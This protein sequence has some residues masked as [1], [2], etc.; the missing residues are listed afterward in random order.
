MPLDVLCRSCGGVYLE[1]NDSD[2]WIDVER[3]RIPNPG[4][5]AFNPDARPNG[6][7]FRLKGQYRAAGWSCFQHDV[8]QVGDALDCPACGNPLPGPPDGKVNTV[9]QPRTRRKGRHAEV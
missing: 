2:G 3:G 4:V 1:T 9:K 7:M 8:S 5:K 6:A